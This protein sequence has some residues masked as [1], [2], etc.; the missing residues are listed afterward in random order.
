M[1]IAVVGGTGYCGRGFILRWS[2]EHDIIIGSRSAEK[3]EKYSEEIM[4][5][6][7]D[8]GVKAEV[9][10]MDNGSAIASSDLVV[11]SVPYRFVE[12]VTRDLEESYSD[13]IVISLIV[14]MSR[15]EDHFEYTP[16]SQGSRYGYDQYSQPELTHRF[17]RILSR[18]IQA[19]RAAR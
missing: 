15:V 14:P 13:Q 11:L 1:K 7:D 18:I 2:R 10:G 9:A 5:Y 4:G 6:L 8:H 19:Q 17:Y 3:A 12:S 16:P